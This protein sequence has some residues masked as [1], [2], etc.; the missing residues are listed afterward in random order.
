[1]DCSIK[2]KTEKAKKAQ[3][4]FRVFDRNQVLFYEQRVNKI[5]F[6]EF[7]LSNLL[8]CDTILALKYKKVSMDVFKP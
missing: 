4:A 1:M 3:M 7:F 2:F 8:L 6:T 5:F